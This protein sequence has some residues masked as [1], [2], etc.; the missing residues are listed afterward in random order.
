MSGG[1]EQ[2]SK[3]PNFKRLVP[4]DESRAELTELGTSEEEQDKRLGREAA[5]K[6]LG[7]VAVGGSKNTVCKHRERQVAVREILQTNDG[8]MCWSDL[9][10]VMTK[11]PY[12]FFEGEAVVALL[13]DPKGFKVDY[14]NNTVSISD[15]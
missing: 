6:V 4:M 11:P 14:F 7:K 8:S 9:I 12:S 15:R 2:I 10:G 1:H 5:E 13:D 3:N